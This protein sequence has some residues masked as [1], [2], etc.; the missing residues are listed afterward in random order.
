MCVGEQSVADT[1]E[2]LGNKYTFCDPHAQLL[3]ASVE[4]VF[5]RFYIRV[6]DVLSRSWR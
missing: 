4:R 5:L 6:N 2:P 1:E 3:F